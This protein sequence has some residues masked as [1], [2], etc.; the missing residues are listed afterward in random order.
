MLVRALILRAL[1]LFP[2]PAFAATQTLQADPKAEADALF[3]QGTEL[4]QSGQYK[5]ALEKYEAELPLYQKACDQSGE[6]SSLFK[7]F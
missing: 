7:D 2:S 5:A 6:A 3:S 4:F 1:I